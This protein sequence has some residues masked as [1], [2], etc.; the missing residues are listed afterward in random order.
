MKKCSFYLFISIFILILS[1]PILEGRSIIYVPAEELVTIEII[2]DQRG[3]LHQSPTHSGDVT[4][5]DAIPGERYIIKAINNSNQR[6][7][8]AISVDG[9]NIITGE[10]SFNRPNESMYVLNPRQSASFEG[11]RSSYNQVQRFYF[12]SEKDS[13]A[14]RKGDS[15]QTGW[16]KAAVYKEKQQYERQYLKEQA[17]SVAERSV[18]S[19][20][21]TGY[22]EGSYSPVSLTDFE[23]E[24]FATQLVNIKYEW[25][26]KY[27][28]PEPYDQ[29]FASPPTR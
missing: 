5:I 2:G 13:Y 14:G 21:G 4:Y 27:F 6:I 10:R 8:M 3:I 26:V 19:K 11:W 17:D 1:F 29:H 28:S 18:S 25:P 20:A 9:L 16:I 23:P 22:G 24:S 15:S 7:A 12:T